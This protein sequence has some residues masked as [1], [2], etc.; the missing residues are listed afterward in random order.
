MMMTWFAPLLIAFKQYSV[1]KSIKSS[2]AA[3]LM[4]LIPLTLSLLT[5]A[6]LFLLSV[7]MLSAILS[8]LSSSGPSFISF[9][10]SFLMLIFMSIFIASTFAL[11]SVTFKEIF[12]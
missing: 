12:K 8:S 2:F 10:I 3:C 4:F 11:Q 6:M 9:I 1:I 5:L 7:F